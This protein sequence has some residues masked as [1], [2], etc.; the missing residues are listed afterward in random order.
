MAIRVHNK[1]NRHA[2]LSL[3]LL[4]TNFHEHFVNFHKYCL[5][6]SLPSRKTER[7]PLEKATFLKKG[8]IE[9]IFCW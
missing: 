7:G 3:C 8:V 4:D 1:N 2:S 5:P 6:L 9:I